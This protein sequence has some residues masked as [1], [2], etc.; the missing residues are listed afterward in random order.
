[1]SISR[2]AKEL[3]RHTLHQLKIDQVY[4][5]ILGQPRPFLEH[6]DL[7]SRFAAIYQ[8]EYW[9]LGRHDVPLSGHGSSLD[10]TTR[11]R[12]E[13][14]RLMT[15][16]GTKHLLDIGCGDFTWMS[17]VD[18]TG[19]SYHGVDVVPAVIAR[20]SETYA[21]DNRRFSVGNAASDNL[22]EAD[23]VLCREVL[24]HLSFAD[25]KA[26]LR[27]ALRTGAVHFFLTTDTGTKFNSDIHSGDYRLLNLQI[28]PFRLP[29][30][31]KSIA[32]LEAGRLL[33]YWT[34]EDI[35]RAVQEA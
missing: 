8:G 7:Q 30:P 16:V 24:F 10:A 31:R 14:P 22:P 34:A 12:N 11:L 21:S 25:A 19:I 33:G 29:P 13:L 15:S 17:Q 4:H 6:Q 2:T 3:I 26:L 23:S 1:M 18:L 9:R 5:R 28:S 20:N 35:R 27:G 32:E